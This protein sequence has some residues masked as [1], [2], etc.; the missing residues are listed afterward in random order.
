MAPFKSLAHR[1]F[2]LLWSGQAVSRLGDSLYQIALA[3][4]VLERTGSAAAMGT[5]FICG[6]VPIVVFALIGG[7][8]S[9]SRLLA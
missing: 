7:V 1:P 8:R 4:W 9:E 5:V 2:L 6:A 3:W